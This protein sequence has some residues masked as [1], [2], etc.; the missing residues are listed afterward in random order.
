[1]TKMR[2]H[3][4]LQILLVYGQKLERPTIMLGLHYVTSSH[5][6]H[7]LGHHGRT[8]VTVTQ[9]QTVQKFAMAGLTY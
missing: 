8:G 2:S 7:V 1:M 6:N 3:M 4:T 5:G 9:L